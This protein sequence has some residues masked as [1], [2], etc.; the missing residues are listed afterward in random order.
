MDQAWRAERTTTART[1][2]QGS[3][4]IDY[5]PEIYREKPQNLVRRERGVEFVKKLCPGKAY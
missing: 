2:N 1:L 5:V 3:E 4:R